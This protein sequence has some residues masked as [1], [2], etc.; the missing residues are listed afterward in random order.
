M[1]AAIWDAIT[2]VMGAAAAATLM[3]R[4][5]KYAQARSAELDGLVVTRE[6]FEYRYVVPESWRT[7]SPAALV[8]L[9]SLTREL[10]PL[11]IEL[12]GPVVLQRL[13]ALPQVAWCNLFSPETSP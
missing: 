12:T 8:A 9:R 13:R 4:A 1:F 5:L 11:L 2:D 10:H 3:R 6:R 7:G